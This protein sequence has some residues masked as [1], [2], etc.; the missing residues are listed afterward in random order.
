VTVR[1]ALDPEHP[2]DGLSARDGRL[3]NGDDLDGPDEV[4]ERTEAETSP[5]GRGVDRPAEGLAVERPHVLQREPLARQDV[6]V[7]VFEHRACPEADQVRT[8]DGRGVPELV[9]RVAQP[10]HRELPGDAFEVAE[11]RPR[12]RGLGVGVAG[13]DRAELSGRV[14]RDGLDRAFP[15]R[16]P[17]VHG[18]LAFV[19]VQPVLP[20]GRR[21][22]L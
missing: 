18:T 14:S 12:P 4:C 20:A 13:P 15:P 21:R 17:V 2:D 11:V 22:V 5:V 8:V 10:R 6:K 1:A 3:R 9:V 7:E 19:V 16:E